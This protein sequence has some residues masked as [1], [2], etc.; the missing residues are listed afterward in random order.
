MAVDAEEAAM[1]A[2][3]G[4]ADLEAADAGKSVLSVFLVV[5]LNTLKKRV[6]KTS[7]KI[8]FLFIMCT[9]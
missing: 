2:D 8:D 4:A 9:F 6:I 5:A 3:A 7:C 1:E